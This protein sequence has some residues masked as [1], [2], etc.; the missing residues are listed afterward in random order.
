[1]KIG[2]TPVLKAYKQALTGLGRKEAR[3]VALESGVILDQSMRQ[4]LRQMGAPK[5]GI[6]EKV[7]RRTGFE[8]VEVMNRILT[9]NAAR[10]HL[11]RIHK[12]F[13]QNPN[14]K[15]LRFE[16]EGM[17][18][19]PDDIHLRRVLQQDDY[20]TASRHLVEKTQFLVTPLDLPM[21]FSSPIGQII[22]QFKSFGFK[23]LQL[24]N[25]EVFKRGN[26]KFATRGAAYMLGAG[27]GAQFLLQLSRGKS[28][29]SENRLGGTPDNPADLALRA[30]GNVISVG[31]MGILA[32]AIRSSAFG[33][34]GAIEFMTGPSV[35]TLAE[36]A[37]NLYFA[38]T[39]KPKPLARQAVKAAPAFL[40]IGPARGAGPLLDQMIFGD[41]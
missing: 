10:F 2:M 18:L 17:G 21:F 35:S 36:T 3:Q 23:A 20:I 33:T 7:L 11:D 29:N 39:G 41:N 34:L 40:P 27:E 37:A 9:A 14:S 13:V 22:T 4:M 16:L 15:K 19:S 28:P 38:G 5:G 30:W 25:D 31:A 12:L 24:A 26:V 1:M 32:D 6:G 8:A